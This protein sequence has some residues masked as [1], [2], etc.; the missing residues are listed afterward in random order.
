MDLEVEHF[1]MVTGLKIE[2]SLFKSSKL[3]LNIGSVLAWK[4][5]LRQIS[6][7]EFILNA[8]RFS[9]LENEDFEPKML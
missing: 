9:T 8:S 6:L 1:D 2:L 7:N 4:Y 3:F 5:S